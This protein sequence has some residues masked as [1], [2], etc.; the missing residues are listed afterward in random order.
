MLR[1]HLME[2]SAQLPMDSS[3][4]Q[5]HYDPSRIAYIPYR[6]FRPAGPHPRP[7]HWDAIRNQALERDGHQCRDC[8]AQEGDVFPGYGKVRLEV[9][10]RHYRNWGHEL[11]DDVTVLC[12]ECHRGVT[13]R[14][15]FWRDQA[16]EINARG[17]D[18]TRPEALPAAPAKRLGLPSMATTEIASLP[19]ANST[20]ASLPVSTFTISG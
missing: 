11:L 8:D 6:S 15:M 18:A 19:A 5:I 7:A 10:H 1:I 12:K 13:D 16:R 17:T 2:T 4:R 14:F 9:H 3:G 20:P